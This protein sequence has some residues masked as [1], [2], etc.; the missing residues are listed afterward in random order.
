MLSI[1]KT[2][3]GDSSTFEDG[4]IDTVLLLVGLMYREVSR[5]ME[6]EPEEDDSSPEQ[7]Q[8]LKF[9]IQQMEKIESLIEAVVIPS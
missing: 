8:N 6:I 9:G 1:A 7:L 3:L 4:K 2:A 5:A